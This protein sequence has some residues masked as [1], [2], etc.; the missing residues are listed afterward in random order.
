M[1]E[2]RTGLASRSPARS[3]S[4]N[5]ADS[6]IIRGDEGRKII[7]SELEKAKAKREA[8]GSRA[9]FRYWMAPGSERQFAILDD[10]PDC[11]IYEH[12]FMNPTTKKRDMV[13][14][15]LKGKDRYCPGC[16]VE[17]STYVLFLTVLD[18]QPFI[19]SK[20][21]NHEF[22]R[23]LMVVKPSS[24]KKFIRMYEKEGTLRGALIEA[25]RDKQ[26][27]PQIGSEHNLIEFITE[28]ELSEDYI[29]SHTYQGKTTEE[30][31]GFPYAYEDIVK[32]LSADEM[33]KLL[34]LDPVPGSRS[35]IERDLAD[36]PAR[37]GVA[38]ERPSERVSKASRGEQEPEEDQEEEWEEVEERPS[39]PS[40]RRSVEAETPSRPV[41]S[42]RPDMQSRPGRARP[43]VTGRASSRR[44][45]QQA[46]DTAIEDE[47]V[48]W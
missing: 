7:D 13:V 47:D 37:P 44:P 27:D 19:D 18:F 29:V 35:Q 11:F 8:A 36:R 30:N 33:E 12:V 23:K 10:K 45:S 1:A 24:Q 4:T 32:V 21:V 3:T 2:R 38:R 22:S 40:G 43:V 48:S 26:T 16:R 20:G 42:P 14:T 5:K 41:R 9:P 15:C 46:Q 39:R 17:D 6:V 25:F 34:N 31:L 28:E